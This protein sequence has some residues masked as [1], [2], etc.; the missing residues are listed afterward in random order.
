M[1][2]VLE[3]VTTLRVIAT[4]ETLRRKGRLKLKYDLTIQLDALV[5]TEP[6]RLSYGR[7]THFAH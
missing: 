3:R 5:E 7:P 2:Q 1:H 6:P 4:V